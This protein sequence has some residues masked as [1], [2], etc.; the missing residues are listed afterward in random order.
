MSIRKYQRLYDGTGPLLIEVLGMPASGKTTLLK[1]FQKEDPTVF[2]VNAALPQ[3]HLLRQLYKLSCTIRQ[4]FLNPA[5]FLADTKRIAA[6]RQR[7]INDFLSVYANWFL[8]QQMYH[9]RMRSLE[10]SKIMFD[11]GLFQSLWSIIFSAGAALDIKGLLLNKYMP[12]I[13][14]I[15]EESDAILTERAQVRNAAERMDYQNPDHVGR[16]NEALSLLTG[17]LTY[18]GYMACEDASTTD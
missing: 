10:S 2:D 13:I 4:F 6:S 18:F 9:D 3:N 12:H 15:L 1:R 7:T 8:I 11:Q 5:S 17:Y 14:F 16:G